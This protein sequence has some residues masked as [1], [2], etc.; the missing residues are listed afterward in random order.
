MS[1]TNESSAN[2]NLDQSSQA[3]VIDKIASMMHSTGTRMKLASAMM[4]V[5]DLKSI[6]TTFE[7]FSNVG[8]FDTT[9]ETRSGRFSI[10]D[11]KVDTKL[12]GLIKPCAVSVPGSPFL[13]KDLRVHTSVAASEVLTPAELIQV[14]FD[15]ANR[16]KAQPTFGSVSEMI[17]PVDLSAV[18]VIS[19]GDYVHCETLGAVKTI[20]IELTISDYL[21]KEDYFDYSV[22]VIIEQLVT[23]IIT[24]YRPSSKK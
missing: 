1:A 7:D 3:T 13:T 5:S 16:F 8:R 2:T 9:I 17:K 24:S 15:L 23:N 22:D 21:Y 12:A 4:P 19:D 20:P 18:S 14:Q 6:L 11:F 10:E